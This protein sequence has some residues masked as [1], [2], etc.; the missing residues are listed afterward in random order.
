MILLNL[1]ITTFNSKK[2]EKILN[3]LSNINLILIFKFDKKKI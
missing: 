3:N 2:I 1:L